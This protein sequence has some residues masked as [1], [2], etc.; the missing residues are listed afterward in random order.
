[1]K[2]RP[3]VVA[4]LVSALT[5]T[6][7][8]WGCSG[9]NTND[10]FGDGGDKQ[11]AAI[12]DIDASDDGGVEDEDVSIPP[13]ARED[14]DVTVPPKDAGLDAADAAPD[15]GFDAG[16]PDLGVACNFGDSG[17][18][19]A[20]G[21]VCCVPFPGGPSQAKCTLPVDC[22]PSSTTVACDNPF[23]CPGQI[24]CGYYD[25]A[26]QHY[27][28]VGCTA[29]CPKLGTAS[30]DD[31]YIFCKPD[32][33]ASQCPQGVACTASQSLKPFYVCD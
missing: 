32:G 30:N 28:S 15:A 11:D 10:L 29:T 14:E 12:D 8:A 23:D 17:A 33:G 21:Q 1:M 16:P 7:A 31:W 25:F 26:K 20:V 27:T 13:D 2:V 5:L 22:K 4:A 9:A 24:C 19:C 18:V 3:S 6:V